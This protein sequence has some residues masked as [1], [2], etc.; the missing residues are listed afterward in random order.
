MIWIKRCKSLGGSM[1][2]TPASA[3]FSPGQSVRAGADVLRTHLPPLAPELQADFDL[4]VERDIARLLPVVGPLCGLFVILFWTWD[5]WIDASH[6][7]LALR[8]RVAMIM[9]GALAYGQGRLRWSPF[10][11]CAWLYATH[12]G[13]VLLCAALPAQGLVL[14]LPGVTGAMFMLALIEP[15]PRNFLLAVLPSSAL[16][17]LLAALRLPLPL[18]LETVLLYALSLPLALGVALANL[19]LRRRAFLS[20]HALLNT[21]RHD[22]L[23]GALSRAYVTELG[24]HDVALALRYGHPL[25]LAMLD[26]D[27]FKRV[28]D[29][30]GHACG[31]K[32]LCALVTA[33]RSSLRASDYVGRIGGEEFICVMPQTGPGDALACAERIRNDVAALSLP[34]PSGPLGFTVSIGIATLGGRQDWEGLLRAADA[35]M[36]AAKAAGRNRTVMA[37][38]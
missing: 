11:R 29:T 36:Y 27:W 12:A 34:T 16:L 8:I 35:A 32:A 21:V 24:R 38:V 25:S 19:G 18:F 22:S 7:A 15:R 28:N 33:C 3:R 23:S 2:V 10:W 13:A 1:N 37:D 26:I 4:Q 6:A 20:E 9:L 14:A 31:D 17:V 5:S 30:Y